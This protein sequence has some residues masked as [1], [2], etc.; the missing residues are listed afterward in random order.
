M[1]C[2]V[3][4]KYLNAESSRAPNVKTFLGLKIKPSIEILNPV[5]SQGGGLDTYIRGFTKFSIKVA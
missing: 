4:T 5:Y 3:W 1:S 2:L